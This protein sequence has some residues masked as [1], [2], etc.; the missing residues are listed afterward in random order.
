MPWTTPKTWADN[1]LVTAALMN[2]QLRDNLE[3]L[4]ARTGGVV[5]RGPNGGGLSTNATS[6][7]TVPGFSITKTIKTGQVLVLFNGTFTLYTSVSATGKVSLHIDGVD[8]KEILSLTASSNTNRA[9]YGALLLTGISDGS[10]VFDLRWKQSGG[11]AINLIDD[12]LIS[13]VVLE[14]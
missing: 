4:K 12:P 1:E 14:V 7:V 9:A 8:T 11:T 3:Y 2:A 13:F 10:H 5:Y 6:Y